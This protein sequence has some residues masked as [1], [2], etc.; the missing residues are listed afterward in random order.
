MTSSSSDRESRG[1]ETGTGAAEA[2]NPE[3]YIK[4]GGEAGVA[5]SNEIEA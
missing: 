5:R 2:V 3:I 4:R 1:P